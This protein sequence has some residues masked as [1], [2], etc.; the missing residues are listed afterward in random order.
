MQ[1]TEKIIWD[2]EEKRFLVEK[3]KQRC[4]IIGICLQ[5]YLLIILR[6]GVRRYF[7]LKGKPY[8]IFPF[9]LTIVQY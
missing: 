1:A 4:H 3:E 9:D 6:W 5:L 2:M 8:S 7:L